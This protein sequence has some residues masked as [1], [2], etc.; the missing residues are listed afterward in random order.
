MWRFVPDE[1][2][3]DEDDS[4]TVDDVFTGHRYSV[5]STGLQIKNVISGLKR[6]TISKH[7][8]RAIV[9]GS[10][11]H[12]YK[13][14][15]TVFCHFTADVCPTGRRDHEIKLFI[16]DFVFRN[17]IDMASIL[18]A[19][20]LSLSVSLTVSL[21]LWV[22]FFFSLSLPSLSLS[23]SLSLPPSLSIYILNSPIHA[24]HQCTRCPRQTS[25]KPGVV[26][27]ESVH[28]CCPFKQSTRL[29]WWVG[30]KEEH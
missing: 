11:Y 7:V 29:L 26:F 24:V 18:A 22:C 12:L 6:Q 28:C 23:L 2:P 15:V 14:V 10:D 3:T 1:W 19:N 17:L 5:V 25:K 20:S 21:S 8:C 30:G 9:N 13:Y 4:V 16:K 27:V